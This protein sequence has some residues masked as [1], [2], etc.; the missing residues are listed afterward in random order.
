[1]DGIEIGQV[2]P[3]YFLG[4]PGIAL[5]RIVRYEHSG[6]GEPWIVIVGLR[7]ELRAR[8]VLGLLECG[9]RKYWKY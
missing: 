6:E 5:P 1:V 9:F 2:L 7:L 8:Q 3:F 4:I